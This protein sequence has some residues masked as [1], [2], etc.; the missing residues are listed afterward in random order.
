MQSFFIVSGS[1]VKVGGSILTLV[2]MLKCLW[3]GTEHYVA[4]GGE[5]N[6]LLSSVCE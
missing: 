4:P 6:T 3:A 1:G 2:P 5:A